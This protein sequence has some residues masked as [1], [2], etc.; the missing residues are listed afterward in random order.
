MVP[1]NCDLET[2]I[3]HSLATHLLEIGQRGFVGRGVFNRASPASHILSYAGTLTAP[4]ARF[5]IY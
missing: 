2:L 4:I 5:D 3:I 1:G